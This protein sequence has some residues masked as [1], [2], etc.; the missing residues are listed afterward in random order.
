MN[1]QNINLQIA[2]VNQ[3]GANFNQWKKQCLKMINHIIELK[4]HFLPKIITV[5]CFLQNSKKFF[6]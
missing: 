6:I 4:Y 3:L 2:T 5:H 1:F